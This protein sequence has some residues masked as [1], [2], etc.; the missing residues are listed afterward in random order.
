ML[1]IKSN[2]REKS[3]EK[4]SQNLKFYRD[5]FELIIS[6]KLDYCEDF[7]NLDIQTNKLIAVYT[8]HC[9]VYTVQCVPYTQEPSK[10]E[11]S[12]GRGPMLNIIL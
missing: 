8:L 4:L 7:A 6:S 2:W 3:Q 12:Q 5:N 1:S 10:P 9:T 11:T